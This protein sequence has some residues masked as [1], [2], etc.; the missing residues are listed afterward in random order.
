V[1]S[2]FK[3]LFSGSIPGVGGPIGQAISQI[4]VKLVEKTVASLHSKLDKMMT[5]AGTAIN[6][7][8]QGQHDNPLSGMGTS[9][10]GGL[11]PPGDSV[12]RNATG[13]M[14]PLTN[15]DVYKQMQPKGLTVE[16]V[17]SIINA[18]N[19]SGTGGGDTYNV[20][21]PEKATVRELA[22]TID[23]KRKV[24]SKGRYSR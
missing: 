5:A 23:F 10:R 9:D 6:V 8:A 24:V 18:S 19:G 11:L 14:E 1:T 22:D 12:V 21:L 4:P 16:D 17:L 20:M 2:L 15:L 3:S 13:R 7:T